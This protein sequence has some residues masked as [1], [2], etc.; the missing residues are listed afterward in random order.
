MRLRLCKN[1][2]FKFVYTRVFH[3]RPS[4]QG[5]GLPAGGVLRGVDP[6]P[7]QSV[8]LGPNG[9]VHVRRL[10][11]HP[12]SR[13]VAV[14][15]LRRQPEIQHQVPQE[16]P[17]PKEGQQGPEG[18][19]RRPQHQRRNS[20]ECEQR[21]ARKVRSRNISSNVARATQAPLDPSTAR[22]RHGVFTQ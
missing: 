16:V 18:T 7:R 22:E 11:R 21:K 8:Q 10:P 12:A 13:G 1:V 19:S 17:R 14:G 5:D 6:C 20:G 9:E 4:V 15:G 3:I 2:Y